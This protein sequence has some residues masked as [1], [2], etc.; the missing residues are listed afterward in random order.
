MVNYTILAGQENITTFEQMITVVNT[1]TGGLFAPIILV[2]IWLIIFLS[3]SVYRNIEAFTAA[4]FIT[5]IISAMFW[6]MGIL[7]P[8]AT[9]LLALM[10]IAG[11][12]FTGK[13]KT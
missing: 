2:C 8:A 4:S 11:A 9:M 7:N 1:M 10:I 5:F 12:F 13:Q 6:A 3:L